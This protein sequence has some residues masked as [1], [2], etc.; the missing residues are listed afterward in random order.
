MIEIG[1]EEF[2][3]ELVNN[4]WLIDEAIAEWE[5]IQSDGDVDGDME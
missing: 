2:I 5:A 1:R 3:A 4:G